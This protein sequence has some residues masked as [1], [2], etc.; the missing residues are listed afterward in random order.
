MAKRTPIGNT[1]PP[2]NRNGSHFP[3]ARII[4]CFPRRIRSEGV[5][6]DFE[7]FFELELISKTEGK[8][9]ADEAKL[10]THPVAN[11]NLTGKYLMM[12]EFRHGAALIYWDICIKRSLVVVAEAHRES[13]GP[14]RI[15]RRRRPSRNSR[16]WR[17]DHS[18][19]APSS[20]F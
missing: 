5:A 19:S 6:V 14:R 11:Q 17:R 20:R 2:V 4:K 12:G 18:K 13:L 15:L 10:P 1:R 7:I 9:L 8:I 3:G 16:N